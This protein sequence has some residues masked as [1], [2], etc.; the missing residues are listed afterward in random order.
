MYLTQWLK[1]VSVLVVVG[2][3]TSGAGLLAQRGLQTAVPGRGGHGQ[4]VRADQIA[5]TVVKPGKLSVIVS[6]RGSLYAS[7]TY[8]AY[9]LVEGRTTII[10]I[11]PEGTPVKKGQIV[12]QLDSAALKDQLVNQKITVKSAEANYQNAK[13]SREVAEIAVLEYREAIFKQDL[14]TLKDEVVAAESA[15][16]KADTRLKRTELARKRLH[17]AVEKKGETT[18]PADILADLDI[19]DRLESAG[20]TVMRERMALEHARGKQALLEKI[21][22]PKTMRELTDE[23]ERA[24]SAELAK[25]ATWEL[26]TSKERKLVRQIL[27]CDIKAPHD[28]VLEYAN[29][30]LPPGRRPNIEEGAT[31]RERQKIFSVVDSNS[32]MIV[33]TKVHES[34]VD[35]LARKMKAKVRVDAF[36]NETRD[37]TVLEI[38][39]LPDL[40]YVSAPNIK[41]YTTKVTID[42]PFPGLKPGMTAQVEFLISEVDNALSVPVDA[43]VQYDNKDHVVVKKPD[44]GIAWREVTLG[45]S[46]DKFVEVKDGIKIGETVVLKPLDFLTEQQ[47]RTV[48]TS[49]TAPAPKSG[50]GQ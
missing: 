40:T 39:P 6:E 38:A 25:K 2:A 14:A 12:C 42:Q 17:E 7:Q 26:E 16:Q 9:S 24:K 48:R 3:T 33:N 13:L 31:V 4:A 19:E 32:P 29:E 47:K 10:Q 43:I 20:L 22:F 44:G 35:K 49:P 1:V 41:V 8:D 28:G 46:D 5:T 37:G 23:V 30:P 50:R 27:N 36:P 11:V 15:I 18:S 45:I 34:Q 21:T